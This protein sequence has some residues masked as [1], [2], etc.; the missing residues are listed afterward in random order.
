MLYARTEEDPKVLASPGLKGACPECG[1]RVIP[2]CGDIVT[3]HWAHIADTSCDNW[4]EETPWHSGWKMEFPKEMVESVIEKHGKTHRA[5]VLCRTGTVI[6]FQHSHLSPEDISKREDFYGFD[7]VWVF[8]MEGIIGEK[9]SVPSPDGGTTEYPRFEVDISG[10][11]FKFLWRM[12]RKS[13]KYAKRRMF[14]DLGRDNLFEVHW[15]YCE[16]SP[17]TGYGSIWSKSKF[18]YIVA[19]S[20]SFIQNW[21]KKRVG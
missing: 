11:R 19:N 2:K 5:D 14:W 9:I 16:K 8:N 17:W 3:W 6:E 13:Y 15:I 10:D 7:L 21:N 4:G 12:P 18:K 20:E 1:A